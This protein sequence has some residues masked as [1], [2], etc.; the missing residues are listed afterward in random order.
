MAKTGLAAMLRDAMD[1]SGMLR[2][3]IAERSGLTQSTLS[4]FAHGGEISTRTADAI[5]EALGLEFT[6]RK[7]RRGSSSR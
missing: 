1:Q 3:E 4:R 7:R 5:A 2:A 6:I